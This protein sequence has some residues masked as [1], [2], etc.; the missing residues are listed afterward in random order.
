MSLIL[1]EYKVRISRDDGVDRPL[2]GNKLKILP[3]ISQYIKICGDCQVGRDIP[4]F[5]SYEPDDDP[6]RRLAAPSL[7]RFATRTRIA[8]SSRLRPYKDPLWAKADEEKRTAKI[9]VITA[10]DMCLRMAPILSQSLQAS[11]SL[12]YQCSF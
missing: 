5:L 12:P 6:R 8:D 7:R 2:P 3:L 4:R 1:K 11:N 9:P 10:I